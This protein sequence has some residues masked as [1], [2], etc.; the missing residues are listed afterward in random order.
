MSK[1]KCCSLPSTSWQHLHPLT[2]AFRSNLD[3]LKWTS[4]QFQTLKYMVALIVIAKIYKSI[5][6]LEVLGGT[7]PWQLSLIRLAINVVDVV[8]C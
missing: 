8:L 3:E 7:N 5:Y 6:L 1:K 2:L 4:Q